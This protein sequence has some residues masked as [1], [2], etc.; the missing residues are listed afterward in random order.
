MPDPSFVIPLFLQSALLPFGVA[1]AV[2]I[3]L[4]AARVAEL[5][6]ALAVAA[7]FLASYGAVFHGQWSLAPQQALDWL[8]WIVVLGGAGAFAADKVKHV[9]LR[10]IIRLALSSGAV[11]LVASFAVASIG[12]QKALVA[13]A[14]GGAAICA[15]WTYLARA[16]QSR[17]TPPILLMVISGGA[18]LA[19]M[20]DASQLIGQL[21]GALAAALVACIAFNI[22]R[23]RSA[24]SGTATAV[25]ILLLGAL[26]ANA[27]FYA[28]F[29][30]GYIALLVAGLL[31]DPLVE[32]FLRLRRRAGGRNAWVPVA[33]LSAVPVVLTIGLAIRAAQEAGGY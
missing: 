25:A 5:A 13:A 26:L 18:A 11:G 24:F 28:G 14:V 9:I 6:P 3:A 31:A 33:V 7:G 8:P 15:A 20:L 30:P 1:L 10:L 29:A 4:R 22:P 23:L 32:G 19:L 27:Y 16:A 2:L 21:S 12:V 17:P